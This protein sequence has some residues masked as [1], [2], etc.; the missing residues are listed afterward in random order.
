[1][2]MQNPSLEIIEEFLAC[3]RIAMVG[4]SRKQ[5]DFTLT[6]FQELCR[7]GY[8][9]IPVNPQASEILGRRCF[10]RV[11]DIQPPAD[12]ALLMTPP[13][14]T[15]IVVRDCAEAGIQRVWMHRASGQGAVSQN[16]VEFCR[17]RGICVVPGQCPLM[18]LP[19]AGTIH[20]LHGLI[21][22]ATRRYPQ[23]AGTPGG[24]AAA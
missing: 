11:Q 17:E 24:R 8:D 1:M 15:E 6:L 12:A 21:R 2:K 4:V 14:V 23:R 19:Q 5:G 16:A 9:V 10:A 13:E 7:R 3:K 22:K 20:R 18:F